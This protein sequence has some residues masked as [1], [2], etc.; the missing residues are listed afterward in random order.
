MAGLRGRRCAVKQ[1]TTHAVLNRLR[2]YSSNT[3]Q[4]K[5]VL[6]KAEASATSGNG[7]GTTKRCHCRLCFVPAYLVPRT[8]TY[9]GRSVGR[10][11]SYMCNLCG[12]VL[13]CEPLKQ[14]GKSCHDLWHERRDLAALASTSRK[15]LL[16]H[17]ENEDEDAKRR[18]ENAKKARL[19]RSTNS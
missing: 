1:F 12:V 3:L 18:K 7:E 15:H 17:R 6:M 4:H 8:S 5:S 13:C 9:H 11:S 16:H 10:S 2:L 19:V 14:G